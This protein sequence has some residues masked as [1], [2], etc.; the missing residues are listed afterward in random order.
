MKVPLYRMFNCFSF[1]NGHVLPQ[2]KQYV[3]S[4]YAYKHVLNNKYI[5]MSHIKHLL[6]YHSEKAKKYT[7]F[8]KYDFMSILCA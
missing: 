3:L 1:K 6:L 7:F 8:F 5:K 4:K 2:H